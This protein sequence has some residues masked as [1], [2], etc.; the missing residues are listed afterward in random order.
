LAVVCVPGVAYF[1]EALAKYGDPRDI[2]NFRGFSLLCL[3][4]ATIFC[5]PRFQAIDAMPQVTGDDVQSRMTSA[6]QDRCYAR[7]I[8]RF[9]ALQYLDPHVTAE[10]IAQNR[11]NIAILAS[12]CAKNSNGTYCLSA[13]KLF[14]TVGPTLNSTGCNLRSTPQ[15]CP[16]SCSAAVQSSLLTPMGCCFGNYLAYLARF[17][18]SSPN[19][20]SASKITNFLNLCGLTAPSVCARARPVQGVLRLTNLAWAYYLL[21]VAE[22]RQA[23]WDSLVYAVGVAYDDLVVAANQQGTVD[24]FSSPYHV[25]AAGSGVDVTYSISTDNTDQASSIETSFNSDISSGNLQLPSLASLPVDS[26]VDSTSSSSDAQTTTGA[27]VTP[28]ASGSDTGTGTGAAIHVNANFMLIVVLITLTF[29]H[30]C[31]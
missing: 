1:L 24:S 9:Y 6:C 25:F 21:H 26:K 16:S 18:D 17:N 13:Y 7:Y 30:V 23:I 29:R 14:L 5:V 15:L 20:I 4:E 27:Y 2:F 8:I 28:S 3:R 31:L 12:L 19:G 22:V 11:Q 10:Q